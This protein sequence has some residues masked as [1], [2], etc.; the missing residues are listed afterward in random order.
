MDV[1]AVP[2]CD[3]TARFFFQYSGKRQVHLKRDFFKYSCSAAR[4]ETFIN[5]REVCGRF[6]LPPGEYLI[7]PSTFEPNKNGDFYVRV[8]SEKEADFQY[9]HFIKKKKLFRDMEAYVIYNHSIQ[10]DHMM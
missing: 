3:Q 9:A 5:L 2:S 10:N 7:I 8:F 1:Y 4:S 6:C